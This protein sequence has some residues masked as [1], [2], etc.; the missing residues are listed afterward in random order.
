[1]F[2]DEYRVIRDAL[3]AGRRRSGL[4]QRALASRQGKSHSHVV[5]IERGQRRVD[6]LEL[7]K[8]A[9]ILA[10]DPRGL[11]W[12][13]LRDLDALKAQNQAATSAPLAA[14]AAR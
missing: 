12:E 11:M 6:V 5:M 7:T 1:M 9:E 10:G 13:I 14:V 2:S 4:S 8:L 3:L